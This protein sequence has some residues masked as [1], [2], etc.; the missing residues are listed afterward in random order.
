MK[1][2]TVLG[3]QCPKCFQ[4]CFP[5]DQTTQESVVSPVVQPTAERIV[6]KG[7]CK[8]KST[9]V[10]HDGTFLHLYSD[11][12]C[13]VFNYV[14]KSDSTNHKV[15]T[16]ELVQSLHS[17]LHVPCPVTAFGNQSIT[18]TDLLDFTK[19][20]PVTPKAEQV[21][22]RKNLNTTVAKRKFDKNLTKALTQHEQVFANKYVA[23]LFAATA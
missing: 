22:P 21:Q 19:T 1:I 23:D 12:P 2:S 10:I 6:R 4:P 18:T 3:V 15:M 17:A 9:A 13:D 16:K 11:E 8:C 20:K 14:I 5:W 7:V